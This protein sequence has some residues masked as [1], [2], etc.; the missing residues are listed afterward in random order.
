MLLRNEVG[1][2]ACS[3]DT[4]GTRQVHLVLVFR[5]KASKGL[6]HLNFLLDEESSNYM[7]RI[8]NAYTDS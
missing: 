5:F 2:L 7:K 6:Q 8:T 4:I 1:L 3:T